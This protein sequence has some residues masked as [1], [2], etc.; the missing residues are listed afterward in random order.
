[1]SQNI[2]TMTTSK[3]NSRLE[4]GI[5]IVPDFP[6]LV[7][8]VTTDRTSTCIILGKLCYTK[9]QKLSHLFLSTC[10]CTCTCSF[11]D[12]VQYFRTPGLRTEHDCYSS[13]CWTVSVDMNMRL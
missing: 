5:E 1:M 7:G 6:S 13:R 11:K 4:T 9:V 3:I 12:I 8:H 10:T 2:T